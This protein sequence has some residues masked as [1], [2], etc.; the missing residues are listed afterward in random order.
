MQGCDRAALAKCIRHRLV[1]AGT[2]VSLTATALIAIY[3]LVVF[4][5]DE[6]DGK[7][8][9]IIGFAAAGA[10]AVGA[11]WYASRYASRMHQPMVDWLRPGRPAT[12]ADRRFLVKVP[13]RGAKLTF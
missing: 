2:L 7:I 6:F 9:R 8:E 10:Y 13:A 11:S 5:Y 3:L 12:D 4:P 1:L